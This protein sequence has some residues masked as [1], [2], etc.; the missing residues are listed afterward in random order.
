MPLPKLSQEDVERWRED[1]VTR[2]LI[3]GF[4]KSYESQ[5]AECQEAYWLGR[6]WPESQRDS[7]HWFNEWMNN[8]F[9][10]DADEINAMMEQMDEQSERDQA[11]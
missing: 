7:L 11:R 6:P 1:H 2:T 10:S 3:S 8:F 9:Q 4:T 5:K